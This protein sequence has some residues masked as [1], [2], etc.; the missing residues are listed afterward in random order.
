M[1]WNATLSYENI[2]SFYN[3]L[4]E[5]HFNATINLKEKYKNDD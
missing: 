5:E 1:L 2:N 3:N 4:V